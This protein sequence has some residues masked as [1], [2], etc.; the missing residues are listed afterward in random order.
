MHPL[1]SII[2]EADPQAPLQRLPSSA[3]NQ[4]L[5]SHLQFPV[6]LHEASWPLKGR[7]VY[8]KEDN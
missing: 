1:H 6:D 7:I 3:T 8:G 4:H 5:C 2:P